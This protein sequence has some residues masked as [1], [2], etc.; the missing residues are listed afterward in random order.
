MSSE[1]FEKLQE[2]YRSLYDELKLMPD[3]AQRCYGGKLFILSFSSSSESSAEEVKRC[4]LSPGVHVCVLTEER[5][6]LVRTF[7]ERQGEAEEVVRCCSLTD[8]DGL[9]VMTDNVQTNSAVHLYA[10]RLLFQVTRHGKGTAWRSC[11]LPEHDEHKA[12]HVPPGPGQAAEGH[13][14]FHFWLL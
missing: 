8:R 11:L 10:F 4:F 3:R 14:H 6:R 13:E 12:P 2:I 7:D 9:K 5:K 1:E